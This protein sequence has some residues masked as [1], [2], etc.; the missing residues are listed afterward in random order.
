MSIGKAK[1]FLRSK[2]SQKDNRPIA[3]ALSKNIAF[4]WDDRIILTQ[5]RG[6]KSI[7]DLARLLKKEINYILKRIIWLEEQGFIYLKFPCEDP[8]L[9]NLYERKISAKRIC[10]HHNGMSNIIAYDREWD[11]YS[12]ALDF[13]NKDSENYKLKRLEKEIYFSLIHRFLKKIPKGSFIIDAG[14]GIGRFAFEL[15]KNG[16]KVHLVDSSEVALKKALRHFVSENL[17]S[18]DLHWGNV[19]NLSMFK[20]NTFNAAFAIELICY[21]DRP[22]QALK[23]LVRVTKKDGLIILSVEGKYGGMLSDPNVSLDKLST[24]LQ[25]NLLYVKNHLYVNYYTP[26]SLESLLKGCGIEVI[27]IIGSHYITDGV[28]H[29]LIDIDKLEDKDYK[30]AV[31]KLEKLCQKDLILKNLARAWVAVGRKK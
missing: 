7:N 8:V 2:L 29:K 25:D 26:R 31:L 10:Q 20:D 27:D 11:V 30:E 1:V 3:R 15:I 18:F 14:G 9:K 24:I 6:G 28:F 5:A 19:S 13:L 4:S 16:Y 22:D 23:E 12:P 21:T 17:N